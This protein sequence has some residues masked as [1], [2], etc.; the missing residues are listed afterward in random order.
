MSLNVAGITIEILGACWLLVAAWRARQAMR[1]FPSPLVYDNYI[2]AL[3]QLANIQRGQFRDQL[4]GF[5]VLAVGLGVQ[6]AA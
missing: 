5:L 6:L 4:A 3:E 1:Y 2:K